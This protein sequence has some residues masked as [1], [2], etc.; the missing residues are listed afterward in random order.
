MW[1]MNIRTGTGL[2]VAIALRVRRGRKRGKWR[3]FT[4]GAHR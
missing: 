3:H 4:V 1:R 2:N